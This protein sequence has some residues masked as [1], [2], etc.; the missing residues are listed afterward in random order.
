VLSFNE[1]ILEEYLEENE[2]KLAKLASDIEKREGLLSL[3]AEKRKMSKSSR[4][5]FRSNA[6]VN[7]ENKLRD[8]RQKHDDLKKSMSGNA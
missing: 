6:E 1:Y 5:H 2:K 8:L 7:H 3:A 4:R